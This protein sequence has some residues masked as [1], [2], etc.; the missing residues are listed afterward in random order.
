MVGYAYA[1]IRGIQLPHY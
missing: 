1:D